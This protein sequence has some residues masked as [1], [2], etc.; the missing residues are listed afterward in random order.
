M[1]V[2]AL[3]SRYFYY[4]VPIILCGHA[5]AQPCHDM[6]IPQQPTTFVMIRNAART[7][8]NNVTFSA[9][10]QVLGP[11]WFNW[12]AFVSTTA[13]VNNTA[14]GSGQ[15]QG[16]SNN[17]IIGNLA[18][19]SWNEQPSARGTG[20]YRNYNYHRSSCDIGD[21]FQ[22]ID[23]DWTSAFLSVSIP[24]ISQL[25]YNN[26]LWYFGPNTPSAVPVLSGYAYQYANLVFDKH[27]TF[28]DSCTEAVVWSKVDPLGLISL[29][30]N[31]RLDA[32]KEGTCSYDSLVRATVDGWQITADILVNSPKALVSERPDLTIS[33]SPSG[34]QTSKF[35]RVVDA[36]PEQYGVGSVALHEEFGTFMNPGVISGWPDPIASFGSGFNYTQWAFEDFISA[37]GSHNPQPVFTSAQEPYAYN[38][39][40]KKAPQSWFVGSQNTG[41]GL[42][43]FNGQIRHY[44]DHGEASFQPQ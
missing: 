14:I 26:S 38:S 29:D 44:L 39:A 9:G 1:Y 27:C 41:A 7:G 36:C 13:Y 12:T 5:Y 17:P 24:Q 40:I 33:V 35:W 15:N 3:L 16:N 8:F 21:G 2:A 6:T 23:E 25:P 22:L 28:G 19:I 10:T 31:G 18:Y 30:S 37:Y 20:T 42:R 4:C 43:V 11:Y 32:V 34:Y